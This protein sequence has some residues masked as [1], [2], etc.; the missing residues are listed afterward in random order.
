MFARFSKLLLVV[1][2]SCSLGLHWAILQSVAWVNMAVNFSKSAPLTE[3]LEKTFDGKHP[4]ALCNAIAE[5]KRSE[6]K[7]EAQPPIVK[8]E[9]FFAASRVVIYPP[10]LDPLQYAA[11]N[12]SAS[13]AESPPVPP[14]RSLHG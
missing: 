14:P 2:L 1:T 8:F 3:A 11:A 4:C 13:H 9:L 12:L 6:R 7:Q 10:S 5:G